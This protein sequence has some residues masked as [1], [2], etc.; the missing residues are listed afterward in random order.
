MHYFLVANDHRKGLQRQV[1]HFAS[2]SL[3]QLSLGTNLSGKSHFGSERLALKFNLI[4]KGVF[5]ILPILYFYLLIKK[6]KMLFFVL[7]FGTKNVDEIVIPRCQFHL[8]FTH[9]FCANI[10]APKI[11]KMKHI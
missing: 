10:L 6:Q 9:A 11:T 4:F 2:R 5:V 3:F 8:H 7:F 1:Q